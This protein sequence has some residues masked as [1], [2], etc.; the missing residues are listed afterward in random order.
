[1]KIDKSIF[2]YDNIT[3]YLAPIGSIWKSPIGKSELKVKRLAIANIKDRPA[4][5]IVILYSKRRKCLL[6]MNVD[7]LMSGYERIK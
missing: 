5:V 7:D 1:M 2:F 6:T 4:P 3:S